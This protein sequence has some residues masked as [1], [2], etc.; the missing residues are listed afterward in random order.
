MISRNG[1]C[2]C[3]S[4]KQYK[5]CCGKET[6]NKGSNKNPLGSFNTLDILQTISA[7]TLVPENHGKNLRLE[8]LSREAIV[9]L[10]TSNKKIKVDELQKFLNTQ[11]AADSGEDLPCNL[12]TEVVAFHGG[13]NLILP[14]ITESPAFTL[15]ALLSAI[16]NWPDT[17]LNPYFK[18][19]I[20]HATHALLLISNTMLRKA[21]LIRYMHGTYEEMYISIPSPERLNVLKKAIFFSTGELDALFDPFQIDKNCLQIFTADIRN[22][23][24][25]DNQIEE[26]P[27]VEQPLLSV[28]GGWLVASPSTLCRALIVAINLLAEEWKCVDELHNA[29]HALIWNSTMMNL[30]RLKYIPIDIPGVPIP[31]H[32]YVKTFFGRFDDDK[33]AIF[34]YL[35]KSQ[36]N[37]TPSFQEL[38]KQRENLF[39]QILAVPE[40]KDYQFIDISLPSPLGNDLMLVIMGNAHSRSLMIN[41]YEFDIATKSKKCSALS[42]WKFAIALYEQVPREMKFGLSF[43][44]E[45]KA[46]KDHQESFY[47]SDEGFD[48]TQ[49]IPGQSQFF[50]E[51]ARLRE[52]EHCM[53][54][55]VDG[56]LA[57][58]YVIRKEKYS[59]IYLSLMDMHTQELQF[60]IEGLGPSVWVKPLMPEERSPEAKHL[61]WEFTDTIAYWLWQMTADIKPLLSVIDAEYICFTYELDDIESFEAPDDTFVRQKEVYQKLNVSSSGDTIHLTIPK[62]IMAYFYGAENEGDRIIVRQILYG[63]NDALTK[64]NLAPLT[65]EQINAVI[66]KNAPF[67]RKK[68]LIILHSRSNM[69]LDKSNLIDTRYIKDYDTSTIANSI[70]KLLG[71]KCPPVGEV[72]NIEDKKQ[73]TKNVVLT[74]LLPLLK[75]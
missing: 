32:D 52:D 57:K 48:I 59:P 16:Y 42:L 41:I 15:N 6:D 53:S 14:G 34:Q 24:F 30:K 54:I 65:E 37:K 17:N 70:C 13:D 18:S 11:Y 74:G 62:E 25:K 9:K 23:D 40:Y 28:S 33:I 21:G 73:L 60:A 20:S 10:N 44:D 26:S 50:I 63:I 1:P 69:L 47:L 22:P 43:L 31:E 68:K 38:A 49:W 3:G 61:F 71:E 45:Y 35:P 5:R 4:G 2:P 55:R 64:K 12:F 29:Y 36:A 19:N 39:E 58:I 8:K 56:R 72:T 67:G 46:Y 7:L 75:E 51:E 27:L 66:E